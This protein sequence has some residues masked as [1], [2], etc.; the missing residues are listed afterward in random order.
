MVMTLPV[1]TARAARA[2]L[3]F[4][5]L[6]GL[7]AS[8]P[9]QDS[10]YRLAPGDRVALSVYG[11]TEMS[12]DYAV[13]TDGNL[14][15]PLI[16]EV[17]V[18]GVTLRDAQNQVVARLVDG[19]VQ[20][21]VV[22][23]RIIEM[24]PI[25]VLGDVRQPG[26]YAFRP[27]LSVLSGIALA[28][29]FARPEQIQINQQTDFLLADERVR[30]LEATRRLYR[31][32]RARLEAQ[33]RN[34]ENFRPPAEVEGDAGAAPIL[35]EERQILT[36]QRSALLQSLEMLQAQK[37]RIEADIA[38]VQAQ[39]TAEETQLRLIQAHMEDYEKLMA[40]GLARRYQGIEFQRE[41]A[42]NKG[43]IAR[44]NSDLARLDLSLGDLA[45]RLQEM[46]DSYQRRILSEMQEATTRLNEAET[47]L[48]S[49]REIRAARLQA[50]GSLA[51][52]ET[53]EAIRQIVITR[54]QD[55]RTETIT[56]EAGTSLL[57]GDIVDV[58]RETPAS[59]RTRAAQAGP[60]IR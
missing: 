37:P 24:R 28:G 41:E 55:G 34:E 25:Y 8:A 56:A 18:A 27:G 44:L 30:V 53:N 16:G 9:A 13:G 50:A 4:A 26:S 60:G 45:L 36:T 2:A 58:R 14:F 11:Q 31:I 57:P 5:G 10:A 52:P 1:P 39:R 29:G 59:G 12:G 22:S 40:N 47:Q 7:P 32:R 6:C 49:A 38:G 51:A 48:S 43:T 20:Q 15:L 35:A 42:R 33:R 46:K 23:L 19:F 17:P 54:V 21:P 3:L